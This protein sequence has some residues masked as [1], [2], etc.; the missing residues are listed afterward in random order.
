MPSTAAGSKNGKENSHKHLPA[1][2]AGEDSRSLMRPSSAKRAAPKPP[3]ALKQST[4]P[5][6]KK[7][8]TGQAPAAAAK[9]EAKPAS[10]AVEDEC[11]PIVID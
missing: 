11:E 4:L 1:A 9:V 8:K 2:L 3:T 6:A 10:T 5:F 7:P